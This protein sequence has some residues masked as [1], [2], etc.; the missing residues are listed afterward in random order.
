MKCKTYDKVISQEEKEA[1]SGAIGSAK[2]RTEDGALIVK[3]S[4]NEELS[5]V[6]ATANESGIACV[7]LSK[8][9]C[10]VDGCVFVDTS[11][12]NSIIFVDKEHMT[13]KAQVGCKFSALVE[14]AAA[15]GFTI[16]VRPAGADPTIEDWIYTEQPGIGSYKYGTVKDSIYNI[17]A[18]SCEGGYLETGFDVIGY[19]MSGFNLIQT[20]CASNGRLAVA[21]EATFKLHPAGVTKAVAYELPDAAKLQ[22][23]VCKISQS[24]SLKPLQISFNLPLAVIAYQGAEEFVDLDIQMTDD[25]MAEVGAVKCDQSVADDKFGTISTGACVNPDAVT[26]YVPMKNM[27]AYIDAAKEIAAFD[28]AGNFPDKYTACIKLTGDVGDEA[29]DAAADKVAEYGGRASNR[30]PSR[31]RDEATQNFINRIEAGFDYESVEDVKLAR[32][33]DDKIIEM[34]K[35]IVGANNVSVSGMDKVL[36]SH[37]MAPLPKEAGLAFNNIPDV[38]V[39]PTTTEQVSE[40]VALAYRYGIPVTPR[41]NGSWGLGG[42]MPTNGGIVIDMPS[43]MNKIIEINGD[44][45]YVKVQAGCTWKRLL[46]ACMKKGYIIGSYPS[47]FPSATLGAWY[48]THG[49]G[50]GSYKYGSAKDNVL[51]AE[52]IVDDGSIVT[53]GWDNVGSYNASFNLNQFFT[54]AEGTLGFISTFTMRLHPMG[55]IRCL[56]YEFDNLKDIDGPM[57]AMVNDASVKPLHIAWSDYLHFANQHKAGVHAPDVKNLWLCTVQGDAQH[58]DLEEAALTAMAE[59]AGG[60]KI[61]NEIAEHEWEERCYEFR[62][63]KVGVGEIPAEVIVP[64]INWGQFSDDCYHGFD[65]MKMDAGG[66]IGVMVDRSTALWMP[67]YFK[68]DEMLTGMLAFG[69]NFYLGDV[70]ARYGG[71]TTG[72]GVFFAWMT[73]VIHNKDTAAMLRSIK[74]VLDPRDVVNPGHVTCG[75]TR[76]GV[77]MNK[78]LMS[79]GSLLMQ[80]VKKLLPKE[81]NFDKNIT[82]FRYNTLEHNKVLDR[83]HKLGDGTQ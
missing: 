31:Y 54:G 81:R 12:M 80:V 61:S 69:F 72:F 36:Y 65:E 52:V 48:S 10:K 57:Q 8:K 40:V 82:R 56:A 32:K 50:I 14:A 38:I 20:L 62:A 26:M 44:E 71:R 11:E 21:T 34:I 37:D 28:I 53:T 49:M 83:V 42:C 67:Y 15:E 1:I 35:G 4:N 77:D 13:I 43:K 60:R 55:E 59:A 18:I 75:M 63:R 23:A 16:G 25:I 7:P 70:A 39:R 51:N 64:T 6:M 2:V 24:P 78:T 47:S 3:P 68:D 41:G 17:G 30:C 33:V 27:V 5:K 19:Y 22:E 73:D 58:N 29:Y 79:L 76:F 9:G 45:L 74:T 66:V 46:E